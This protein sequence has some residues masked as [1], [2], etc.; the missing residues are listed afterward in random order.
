MQNFPQIGTEYIVP[1]PNDIGNWLVDV[2]VFTFLQLWFM[3]LTMMTKSNDM[4]QFIRQFSLN[5]LKPMTTIC[6]P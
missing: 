2:Y 3:P 1:L 5:G 4:D 6:R